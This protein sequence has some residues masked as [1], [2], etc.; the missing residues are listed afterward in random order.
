M[1]EN[2]SVNDTKK[3]G[4]KDIAWAFLSLI[5]LAW[6]GFLYIAKKT[7]NYKWH[8]FGYIHLAIWCGFIA[9][10]RSDGDKTTIY[11]VGLAAWVCSIIHSF[12]TASDHP[13]DEIKEKHVVLGQIDFDSKLA[14]HLSD[15]VPGYMK[16]AKSV[17]PEERERR[18]TRIM[19]EK[20]AERE[21]PDEGDL[22]EAFYMNDS[23]NDKMPALSSIAAVTQHKLDINYCDRYD[24]Q[25]L[26]GFNVEIA[27]KAMKMREERGGFVSIDEFFYNLGV[28]PHNAV[29]IR[30]HVICTPIKCNDVN[31]GKRGR[32][33]DL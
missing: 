8:F 22:P 31:N 24:F 11:V 2:N 32:V 4:F 33:L 30:P 10:L 6:V 17:S 27:Q 7:G 15:N 1:S 26:P 16:Y 3:H 20:L 9:V 5:T 29:K 13:L 18:N 19:A 25:A 21:I 28:K 14:K 23:D 12:I